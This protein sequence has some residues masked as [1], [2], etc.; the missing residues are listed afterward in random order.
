MKLEWFWHL[1][2]NTG[3]TRKS[4]RREV[5]DASIAAM[6]GMDLLKPESELP[7]GVGYKINTTLNEGGAVFTVFKHDIP[8]V[9][10]LLAVAAN[11][12]AYWE[13][14]ERLYFAMT[15]KAPVDWALPEKPASTPWLADVLLGVH[16]DLGDVQWLGDFERCMV[17]LLIEDVFHN[18]H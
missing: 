17:W 7:I 14:I 12:A 15:D 2:L 3:D 4:Y 8:L 11:D 5:G 9:H 6:R 10:C 18:R 16:H 1:T 13:F